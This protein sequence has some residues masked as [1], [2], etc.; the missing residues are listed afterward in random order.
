M[1]SFFA[2]GIEV[3]AGMEYND[4]KTEE[5]YV[6]SDGLARPRWGRGFFFVLAGFFCIEAALGYLLQTV[7]EGGKYF[8]YACVVLACLFCAFLA[9]RSAAYLL[10]QLALVCTVCADWFLVIAEPREQLPAML[11]FSCAQILYFLRIL[12]SDGSHVR[13]RVHVTL[14]AVLSVAAALVTVLVLGKKTDAVALVSVFYYVQ[15]LLNVTFAFL[16]G[17]VSFFSVG[18]LLFSLCDT[19]IGLACMDPYLTLPADSF[20]QTLIHPGF[21]LAWAFYVPSQA[22]IAAS[23][24]SPQKRK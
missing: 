8:S 13:R 20:V 3:F 4:E 18:L 5:V 1:S 15:L 22:L 19:L 24:C 6:M 23:L 11:F 9:Q 2:K 10:T 7:S 16:V 14:R 12:F 17:G 21:D